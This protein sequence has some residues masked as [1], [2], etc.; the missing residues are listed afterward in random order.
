MPCFNINRELRASATYKICCPV[1]VYRG[2]VLVHPLWRHVVYVHLKAG[3]GG[4]RLNRNVSTYQCRDSH[5][6]DKTVSRLSLYDRNAIPGKT[7]F[8]LKRDPRTICFHFHMSSIRMFCANKAWWRDSR[9]VARKIFIGLIQKR[10]WNKERYF[11][12]I[13]FIVYLSDIECRIWLLT[14]GI[15][16][17]RHTIGWKYMYMPDWDPLLE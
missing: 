12:C 5:Y 7:V 15:P 8:V 17:A 1:S 9:M 10:I 11:G 6:K 16:D 13:C 2:I 4:G 14:M 3:A